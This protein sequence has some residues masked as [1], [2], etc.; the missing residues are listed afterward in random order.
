MRRLLQINT[1]AGW[2]A[3]AAIAAAIGRMAPQHG[4]ES[5]IAYGRRGGTLPADAGRLE[6]IG[7]RADTC[8]HLLRSRLADG[9]GLGSARTTRRLIDLIEAT[10]PHIIHLHNIHGYYLHYPM[11]MEHLASRDTPV[12]WTVH[13]CWPITGHCAAPETCT[14]WR[15]G[16][17]EC[18]RLGDYPASWGADRSA[19]NQKLK[20]EAFALPRKMHMVAVSQWLADRLR[21]SGIRCGQDI[22][23]IH[24]GLQ[25]QPLPDVPKSEPPLVLAVANVWTAQ[26][27][28]HHFAE[29]RRLLPRDMRLRLVGLTRQ[30]MRQL[31]EGI[32][33]VERIAS[34]EE[35]RRQY[36]EAAVTV[37]L[38]AAETLGM[39]LIESQECG[40]PVV[41]FDAGGTV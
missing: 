22:S 16:C 38:S 41:A 23:F 39:T 21:E 3:P 35:L 31:P 18:P 8:M 12:V 14:R 30:Q 10:D 32:E 11:L 13:D 24:N 29:L 34:R 2:S 5:I 25:I 9:H 6:Y 28:L 7:S 36:A 20:R 33:G 27:G 26:K 19:R 15:E 4:Y 17:R 1:V 37:S 40:T